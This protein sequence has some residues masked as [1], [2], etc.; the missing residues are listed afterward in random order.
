MGSIKD[1]F[2]MADDSVYAKVG[3]ASP[4]TL[5]IGGNRFV[6]NND[7]SL[8]A[9]LVTEGEIVGRRVGDT[10]R[11]VDRSSI[12]DLL[13]PWAGSDLTGVG[14]HVLTAYQI[15]RYDN[16][17]A[18]AMVL[19][20]PVATGGASWRVD[21][22]EVGNVASAV[23]ITTAAGTTNME[24]VGGGISTTDT[25]NIAHARVTY[26]WDDADSIWRIVYKAFI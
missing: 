23:T 19:H 25:L 7:S 11:G 15:N 2:G 14:P 10:L 20:I 18:A 1:P 24:L 3:T 26:R 12:A 13:R 22:A 6:A 9:M 17:A 4:A 16:T 5:A 8:Q 21:V